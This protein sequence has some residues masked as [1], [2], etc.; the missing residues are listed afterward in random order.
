MSTDMPIALAYAQ[1]YALLRAAG[2]SDQA[3]FDI[4]FSRAHGRL[5]E[6]FPEQHADI[7]HTLLGFA[8]QLGRAAAWREALPA[9]RAPAPPRA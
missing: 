1:A 7:I 8:R 5:L 2:A 3:T 9:Q 6:D 4:A